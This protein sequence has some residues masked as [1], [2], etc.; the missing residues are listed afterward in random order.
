MVLHED[1]DS[2]LGC[3]RAMRVFAKRVV[4]VIFIGN[5]ASFTIVAY[6]QSVTSE[7]LKRLRID[8]L[9]YWELLHSV[10]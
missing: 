7:Q 9:V 5:K 6:T 1:A 3:N 10:K 8:F 2:F 4:Y